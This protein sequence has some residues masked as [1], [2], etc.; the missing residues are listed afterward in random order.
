MEK[1]FLSYVTE[2]EAGWGSRPDGVAISRSKA[3]LVKYIIKMSK[4]QNPEYYWLY[5]DPIE[6]VTDSKGLPSKLN[7]KNVIE[8]SNL[9][10][11]NWY[12]N[13]VSA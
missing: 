10:K 4:D 11:G 9:P 3:A 1:L 7:K 13:V 2:Y 8:V 12:K 5:S 6:M